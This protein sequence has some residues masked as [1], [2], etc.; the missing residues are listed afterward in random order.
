LSALQVELLYQISTLTTIETSHH[1]QRRAIESDCGME[2]SFCVE[3]RQLSPMV[4]SNIVDLAFV[5]GFIWQRGTYGKYLTFLPFHQYTCESMSSSFK[6]HISPL[7]ESFLDKFIAKL[8]R[9]SWFTSTS[10]EYASF[11][12]LNRHEICRDLNV[13]NIRPIAVGPE[14]VHKQIV[15]IV[16]EEVKSVEHI[17]V[18]FENGHLECRFNDLFDF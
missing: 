15:S 11:L 1:I 5:H 10:Q 2:V 13:D 14:I 6:K 12:V 18:V 8:C 16:Y 3:A 4:E 9:F 17:P 7:N